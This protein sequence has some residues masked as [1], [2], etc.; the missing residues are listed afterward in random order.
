LTSEQSAVENSFANA[1]ASGTNLYHATITE[2]MRGVLP[3]IGEAG[4]HE[5]IS[6][7][8]S[9]FDQFN[10]HPR[11]GKAWKSLLDRL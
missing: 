9:Q 2:L 3:V 8:G 11:H 6:G 1:W 5:F 4:I 10:T 7:V